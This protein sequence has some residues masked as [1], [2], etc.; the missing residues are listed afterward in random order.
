M[1]WGQRNEQGEEGKAWMPRE[2]VAFIWRTKG[3]DLKVEKGQRERGGAEE[4][5]ESVPAVGLGSYERRERT[6]V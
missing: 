6:L 4:P 5:T 2:E 3:R 1:F